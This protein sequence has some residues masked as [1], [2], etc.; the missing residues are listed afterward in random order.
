M[1]LF[2]DTTTMSNYYIL[3]LLGLMGLS[4]CQK[5]VDP[6][7]RYFQN[8]KVLF[9]G[10]SITQQGTYVSFISYF[11]EKNYPDLSTEITSIGLG[12]E[13]VSCLTENDHPFP[14]PCLSERIDRALAEIKPDVVIACYGM[15]DGIYHP[16]TPEYEKAFQQGI[17]DLQEK[18]EKISASLILLTPPP[19]DPLPIS[20]R[21]VGKDAPEF[22][23][24]TPYEKYDEVLDAYAKWELTLASEKLTVVDWHGRINAELEKRRIKQAEFSF[25]RDG[26]HPSTEGHYLMA[27]IFMEDLGFVQKGS[28]PVLIEPFSALET[29]PE[30]E[31]IH[32]QRRIKSNSWLS[33]I[34]Y[35]RGKTVKSSSPKPMLILMGGQSNMVGQGK[36]EELEV[37]PGRP[38]K[39]YYINKGL[40]SR[41]LANTKNFG[42]EHS[43]TKV[44]SQH[45]AE[46]YREIILLKYAI[47]GSSL[48]DWA[49]DY[50]AE[51]AEITGNARFGNMY[52]TFFQYIDSVQEL[53]G[54]EP[55][56][57]L[58]MQGERDARI[59]EAGKE[60]YPNFKKFIESFRERIGEPNLPII[61]AKVNPPQDRY[62]ALGIV[63]DAQQRIADEMEGV[64]MIETQG[65]D[66]HKDNLHYNTA[67]QLELGRRFA[68]ELLKEI[69]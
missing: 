58:W 11:L 24:K 62:P 6:A 47:G 54:T 48:L 31:L 21:L 35:T 55:A 56:A 49:P 33:Y 42:P 65:L 53:Y 19:F 13:T 64:S 28:S 43:L 3:L 51:K 68:E 4:A 36:I 41:Q 61:F 59:P 29:D 22:G 57:L 15:N 69:R 37:P 44:L 46:D 12:S 20:N 10:N 14:R 16:L 17:F 8:K 67:G 25:A 1:V 27:K 66:K 32:K 34:G 45:F 63:N 18:V 30:V 2:F 9:L 39:I 60:Y 52:E 50:S 38:D 26:V 5:K 40:T 7:E 23:Y